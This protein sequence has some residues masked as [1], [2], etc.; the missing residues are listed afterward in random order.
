[1][2]EKINVKQKVSRHFSSTEFY[3]LAQFGGKNNSYNLLPEKKK[4]RWMGSH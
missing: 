3:R 4:K 2:K 1:M